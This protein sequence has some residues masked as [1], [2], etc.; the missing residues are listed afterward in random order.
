MISVLTG[1]Y[2]IT[3]GSA[4]V[5]GFDVKTQIQ[6]IYKSIGICPQ[7]DILW[8]DLSISE[9]LYFYARLKGVK[10][11]DENKVVEKALKDVNLF[12]LRKRITKNLSGGERRRLSI[13]VA[14]LGD[15]KVIFLDEPTT[16]LDPEVRRIIWNIISASRKGRTVVL[17]THSMEVLIS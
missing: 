16:G 17:T 9:H 6:Q 4:I 8:G 15:P 13:A 11:K 12:E 1:L 7:F 3:S 10:A 2:P 14:L 5:G